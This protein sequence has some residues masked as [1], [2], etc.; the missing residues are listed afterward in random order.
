VKHDQNACSPLLLN[1][2]IG[3]AAP[4]LSQCGLL[5]LATGG[6]AMM[7]EV[8][9]GGTVTRFAHSYLVGYLFTV[10]VLL[11]SLLFVLLQHIS[12]AGWATSIRRVPEL[13]G[14]LLPA[15]GLLGL[16][17]LFLLPELY[18]WAGEFDYGHHGAPTGLRAVLMQPVPF[19]VRYILY[20]L[21]W[22]W[23]GWNYLRQ[24]LRQDDIGG[25]AITLRLQRLGP[26]ATIAWGITVSLF[27]FDVI[28][29]LDPFWY[30]TM[31]GVYFF[32][33]CMVGALSAIILM[34]RYRERAGELKDAV[35]PTH[36]HDL[37]KL[38]FAFTMF[39]AY[40]A[41]SQYMLI[42]Y[43]NIPEETA[44]Y[45]IRLHGQW[46]WIGWILLFGHFVIPFVAIMSRHAKRRASTLAFWAGWMLAMHAIDVWWLIVPPLGQGVLTVTFGD[47]GVLVAFI[48]LLIGGFAM[49]ARGS[50]LVSHRDPR[51]TESLAHA[52]H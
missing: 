24:S 32:S 36:Y 41:F 33:G 13:M 23:M 15:W 46:A 12:A 9:M 11:G 34:V 26:I 50:S 18:P 47:I 8:L 27:A 43:A 21:V 37:G 17:I 16:P 49:I 14:G 6:L 35:T 22:G 10:S 25:I 31:I 1:R 40:I 19:A 20:L 5:L 48:G 28:M 38:L 29:S 39:W 30:T 51:I 4:A 44:W 7:A 3:A 45:A 2:P 42:W 52:A